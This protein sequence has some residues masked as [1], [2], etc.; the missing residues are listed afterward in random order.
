MEYE[1]KKILVGVDLPKVV[2]E[3]KPI[4]V[5]EKKHQKPHTIFEGFKK[6]KLKK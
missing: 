3:V 5:K 6:T 1:K 4:N 2:N